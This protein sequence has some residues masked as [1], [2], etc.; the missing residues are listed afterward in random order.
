M[1]MIIESLALGGMQ[2]LVKILAQAYYISDWQNADLHEGT[3]PCL[4]YNLCWEMQTPIE[5]LVP[6]YYLSL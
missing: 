6:A 4:L 3:K 5:M 1:Q 2:I